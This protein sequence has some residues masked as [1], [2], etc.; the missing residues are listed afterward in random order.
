MEIF[1]YFDKEEKVKCYTLIVSY[2]KMTLVLKYTI[3]LL[4][5]IL[6]I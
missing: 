2:K 3:P 1:E 6:L 5:L 4:F